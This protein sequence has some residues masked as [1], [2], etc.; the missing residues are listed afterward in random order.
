MKKFI[1][2]ISFLFLISCSTSIKEVSLNSSS[3]N[4][5]ASVYLK[6]S[7]IALGTTA[8]VKIDG[9][10]VG[11]LSLGKGISVKVAPGKHTLE[12]S[13]WTCSDK[14]TYNFNIVKG[15]EINIDVGYYYSF[16]V[17]SVSLL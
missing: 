11:N 16:F 2:V 17:K 9:T 12:L 7:D 10:K 14:D 13:C 4:N 3:S 5:D 1:V 6:R 8:T 15:E